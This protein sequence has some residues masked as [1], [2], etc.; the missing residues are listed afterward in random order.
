MCCEKL[1]RNCRWIHNNAFSRTGFARIRRCYIYTLQGDGD[2]RSSGR[3]K[4]HY[5]IIAVIAVSHELISISFHVESTG[6][7]DFL[8][9]TLI[10]LLI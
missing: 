10:P 1:F 7:A 2:L 4:F 3:G 6:Y 5:L 9:S 8:T